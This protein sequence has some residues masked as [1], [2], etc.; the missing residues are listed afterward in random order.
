MAGTEGI[1][2]ARR[3]DTGWEAGEQPGSNAP[4]ILDNPKTDSVRVVGALPDGGCVVCNTW[5]T[6]SMDAPAFVY[7]IVQGGGGAL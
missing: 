2:F 4:F 1:R 7:F 5:R 3:T 6:A